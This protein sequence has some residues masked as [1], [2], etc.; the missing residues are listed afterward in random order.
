MMVVMRIEDWY[1]QKVGEGVVIPPRF[2]DVAPRTLTKKLKKYGQIWAALI[3]HLLTNQ[4][5]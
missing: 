3:G 5:T 2:T 4:S 1:D